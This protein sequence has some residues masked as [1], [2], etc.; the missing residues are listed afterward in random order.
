[1]R[2]INTYLLTYFV[3][4]CELRTRTPL[5]T[6]VSRQFPGQLRTY[7]RTSNTLLSH[8]KQ[9]TVHYEMC[10]VVQ[11]RLSTLIRILVGV[12]FLL[13]I[14]SKYYYAAFPIGGC[15][16]NCT[17]SISLF[18]CLSVCLSPSQE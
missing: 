5:R 16:V 6:S 7:V 12:G 10:F 4:T 9:C 13:F 17:L 8:T 3:Y 2:S 14:M 18:I 15:I 11:R 1:M